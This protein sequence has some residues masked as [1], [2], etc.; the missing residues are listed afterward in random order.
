MARI[1][2]AIRMCMYVTYV[3]NNMIHNNITVVISVGCS[4]GSGPY[5]DYSAVQTREAHAA[6]ADSSVARRQCPDTKMS[7]NVRDVT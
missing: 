4:V 1:N 2:T 3:G 7:H 5:S 6:Q